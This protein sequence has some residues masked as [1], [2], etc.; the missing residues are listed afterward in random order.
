[1]NLTAPRKNS[2]AHPRL[3]AVTYTDDYRWII[4]CKDCGH[5]TKMSQ[6]Q[7]RLRLNAD[8]DS[9]EE[10]IGLEDELDTGES[11]RLPPPISGSRRLR[12]DF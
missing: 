4:R 7:W 2:C 3:R 12:P 1:M 9:S 6:A 11:T 8:D 5:E 10:E